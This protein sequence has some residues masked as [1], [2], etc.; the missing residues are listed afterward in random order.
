[1]LVHHFGPTN[2]LEWASAARPERR[3][4]G[5][6]RYDVTTSPDCPRPALYSL[7][8]VGVDE[9]VA[10]PARR[11]TGT[12]FL[13]YRGA[14]NREAAGSSEAERGRCRPRPYE[15]RRL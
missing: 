5:R 8:V 9:G 12:A 3:F 2:D 1:M 6:V 13:P 15:R 11:A 7:H 4:A 10:G 14:V